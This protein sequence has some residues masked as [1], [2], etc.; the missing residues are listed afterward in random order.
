MATNTASIK[1]LQAQINDGLNKL[2]AEMEEKDIKASTFEVDSPDECNKL[3]P[4]SWI[5]REVIATQLQDL[6]MLL[7]GPKGYL[8]NFG[9]TVSKR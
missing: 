2:V 7:Q 5:G 1:E 6:S 3:D 4:V 9:T 8:N